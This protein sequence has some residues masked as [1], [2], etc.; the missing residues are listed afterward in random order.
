[1]T[2]VRHSIAII[3]SYIIYSRTNHYRITYKTHCTYLKILVR[4]VIQ[5]NQNNM[6]H[7]KITHLTLLIYH[8]VQYSPVYHTCI[9]L[10]SKYIPINSANIVRT[11]QIAAF[12]LYLRTSKQIHLLLNMNHIYN[13]IRTFSKITV[14]HMILIYYKRLQKLYEHEHL[15]FFTKKLYLIQNIYSLINRSFQ[16]F[17]H[18]Y[19]YTDIGS[20]NCRDNISLYSILVPYI[21][22]IILHTV[23]YQLRWVFYSVD[24]VTVSLNAKLVYIKLRFRIIN[25]N[26]SIHKKLE[27][28]IYFQ[29]INYIIKVE[30]KKKILQK[31]KN[32]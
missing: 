15:R 28:Q 25:K 11:F 21:E 4:L 12:K 23:E 9:L 29:L 19:L 2:V 6:K 22:Y 18:I 8:I 10:R 16:Y 24:D 30:R 31:C 7:I 27:I 5:E 20:K 17:T 3:I 14:T 26:N 32:C 13:V 1:M